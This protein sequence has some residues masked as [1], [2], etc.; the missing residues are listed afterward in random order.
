MPGELS[1][2]LVV[3]KCASARLDS[4]DPSQALSLPGVVA[5]VDHRWE[6]AT[7]MGIGSVSEGTDFGQKKNLN[8]R[9]YW[10]M[11]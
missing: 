3:S 11:V 2:A 5:F 8:Q 4:V 1:A 7:V 9:V 6:P 10:F